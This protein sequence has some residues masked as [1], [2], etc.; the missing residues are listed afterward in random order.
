MKIYIKQK[1]NSS[2][3]LTFCSHWADRALDTHIPFFSL[4]YCCWYSSFNH[5]KASSN[6]HTNERICSSL[7]K[8]QNELNEKIT[9]KYAF[10]KLISNLWVWNSW[11]AM[12][13]RHG[14]ARNLSL[15]YYFVSGSCPTFHRLS[16]CAK[17]T[18]CHAQKQCN[19]CVMRNFSFLAV[20]VVVV[21]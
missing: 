9:I 14:G 16:A 8:W 11:K 5:L 4:S 21:A 3:S 2:S 12:A 20:V 10:Y 17:H 15:I 19:G 6:T 13:N 7:V 18:M 1:K